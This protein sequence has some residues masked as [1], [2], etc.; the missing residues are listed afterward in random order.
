MTVRQ[1]ANSASI[2]ATLMLW[3]PERIV[4]QGCVC[5]NARRWRDEK[6]A[7]VLRRVAWPG[8]SLEFWSGVEDGS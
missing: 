2:C 3:S 7:A 5:Y 8:R 6:P 1:G 4:C